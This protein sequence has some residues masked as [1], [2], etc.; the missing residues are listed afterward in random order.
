MKFEAV[1]Y[2]GNNSR[3]TDLEKFNDYWLSGKVVYSQETL[4]IVERDILNISY[5]LT[6]GNLDLDLSLTMITTLDSIR[7]LLKDHLLEA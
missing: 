5:N 1:F 2:V 4:H 6:N 7:N 3:C